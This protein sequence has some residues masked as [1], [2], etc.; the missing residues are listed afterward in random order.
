[1]HGASVGSVI[2]RWKRSG[3]GGG[4]TRISSPAA[5]AAV[6]AIV[7]TGTGSGASSANGSVVE[8]ATLRQFGMLLMEEILIT[9]PFR[10]PYARSNSLCFVFIFIIFEDK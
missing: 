3:P 7:S 5:A 8:I 2:S 6:P 1:M 9:L 10:L 4:A